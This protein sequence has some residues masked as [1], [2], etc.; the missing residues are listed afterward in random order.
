MHRAPSSTSRRKRRVART[1]GFTVVVLTGFLAAAIAAGAAVETGVHAVITVGPADPRE[2]RVGGTLGGFSV[3]TMVVMAMRVVYVRHERR[4]KPDK[5]YSI[6]HRGG[7][8][9]DGLTR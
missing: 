4:T 5:T 8:N 3:G 6:R 9:D 1:A 2:Q 7:K